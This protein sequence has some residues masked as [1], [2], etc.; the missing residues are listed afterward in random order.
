ML[1]RLPLT[2]KL[3]IG[4][5]LI[6]SLGLL[7]NYIY[8][9]E[10][11]RVLDYDIGFYISITYGMRN[12][13]AGAFVLLVRLF[14]FLYF[15]LGYIINKRRAGAAKAALCIS[16][17]LFVTAILLL[18]GFLLVK[19][20]GDGFGELLLGLIY[21]LNPLMSG[22]DGLLRDDP[23][24]EAISLCLL[25]FAPVFIGLGYFIKGRLLRRK[26]AAI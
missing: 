2:A 17:P 24:L 5:L 3:W 20:T 22:I 4:F 8:F 14:A 23:R 18:L 10:F 19:L 11:M 26:S 9:K 1:K 13:D 6:S 25:F 7:L 12:I 16:S 21:F 15:A